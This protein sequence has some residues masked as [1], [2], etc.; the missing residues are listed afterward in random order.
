VRD[1]PFLAYS[2][3][4]NCESKRRKPWLKVRSMA[5]AARTIG[6]RKMNQSLRSD[7]RVIDDSG[8]DGKAIG[9]SQRKEF[10][11]TD[12]TIRPPSGLF[13]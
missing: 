10:L 1:G 7:A 12:E 6:A 3:T 13:H 4:E 8:S 11:S 2:F 9:P 5:I